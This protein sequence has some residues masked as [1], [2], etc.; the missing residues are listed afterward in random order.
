MDLFESMALFVRIAETGS[1]SAAA[2]EFNTTQPT[3]SKRIADLESHLSTK[4][5]RRTTRHIKLT[6]TGKEYYDRCIIILREMEDAEHAIKQ[7]QT[8]P[9]GT[10]KVTTGVA[11]GTAHILPRLHEFFESYPGLNVI[12]HLTDQQ[13]DLV[14]EGV[15][16]ALRM[17]N[18]P[19]SELSAKLICSSPMITVAS[20][21]H[22]AKYGAPKHP[23]E[24]SLHPCALYSGREKPRKWRF[25]ENDMEIFVDVQGKF[26]T[27]D[28]AAYRAALLAN[29]GLGVVPLWLVGDLIQTGALV[30]ILDEFSIEAL[31]IHAVYPPGKRISSKV[32]YF[33]EFLTEHL[34]I[35]DNIK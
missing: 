16:I 24:L 27:N 15:D 13:I 3:A 25:Q 30:Q 6:D 31:P 18:L 19:D 2:K 22:I 28:A 7:L 1:F 35:C 23:K 12:L 5:L 11:F 10:I 29:L 14:Q 9:T 32:R 8:S 4:L 17:G 34:N 26:M 20:P 21:A 33:S